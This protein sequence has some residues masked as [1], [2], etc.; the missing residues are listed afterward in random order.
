[1]SGHTAVIG[2]QAG[3]EGKGRL[4]DVLAAEHDIVVR[5]QGGGNAGHTVMNG[6]NEYVLHLVPC[7]AVQGK[8]NVIGN[9]VALNPALLLQ[10]LDYCARH[11]FHLTPDN[12]L[13]SERAHIVTPWH[14]LRDLALEIYRKRKT[15]G[16][17]GTTMQGI[18][19]TYTDKHKRSGMR[20]I[21]LMK[22]NKSQLE[23]RLH[24]IQ[25]DT[26]NALTAV[27]ISTGDIIGAMN[28]NEETQ[29]M[30]KG[31]QPYAHPS[32]FIDERIALEHMLTQREAFG[33]H[34]TDTS[35]FLNDA[36]KDG[37]RILF[38]GAQ[39]TLLDIDHGTYPDVTSSSPTMG[40][41]HT[42]TGTYFP[43]QNRIGVLKA[44]ITRVGSGPLP[45]ADPETGPR[46]QERGKE[47]GATTGR[48]RRCGNPD[49]VIG[50]YG[51]R[52]S[53]VNQIALTKLDVL[54]GE[55]RIKI[56]NAYK[57]H[58]T[59]THHFPAHKDDLFAAEPVYRDVAGWN[60]EL[61]QA[62]EESDLPPA[63]REF[64]REVEVDLGVPVKYVSVG[65]ERHQIITRNP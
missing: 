57:I 14:L 9:G 46:F 35:V 65:P 59:E 17:I 10:E 56:A 41:I 24:A 2:L 25:I 19:P 6:G 40:G 20:V 15:G 12:L 54:S 7:G 62:K 8:V 28:K 5:A 43:I 55:Q 63:A 26:V 23:D 61:S 51:I 39:G 4:V 30:T 32:F 3:D 13:I 42:G 16:D 1:M 64:I 21:E 31:L 22:A 50:R 37:A 34:V 38:E 52:V 45:T 53:G 29:R 33:A 47:F 48:T 11:D 58:G 49:H 27:D 60:Q 44:Y 18:G 36:D